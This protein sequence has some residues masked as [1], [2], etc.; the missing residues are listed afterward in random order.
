MYTHSRNAP[1][2]GTADGTRAALRCARKFS[3]MRWDAKDPSLD[4]LGRPAELSRQE[5]DRSVPCKLRG[6]RV[7]RV[8][9]VTLE[10]P[11]PG[12]RICVERDVL[13]ERAQEFLEVLHRRG[14]L[15]LVR[16]SEVT[17]EGRLCLGKLG[18]I[19]IAFPGPVE[20]DG[21]SQIRGD[22]LR[23]P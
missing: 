19:V 13:R 12:P 5:L 16:L 14:G 18:R 23:Q 9:S 20:Q 6:P 7:V 2:L 22:L 4:R 17:E 3:P 10:E 11:V 15:K 1:T 8:G 21:R